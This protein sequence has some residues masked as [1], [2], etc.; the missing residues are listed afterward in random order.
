MHVIH[1]PKFITIGKNFFPD[2]SILKQIAKVYFI[3]FQGKVYEI[4]LF[5]EHALKFKTPEKILAGSHCM[6]R[7]I[8]V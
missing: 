3:I 4:R 1:R 5:Q 7:L 6:R 2:K 8:P